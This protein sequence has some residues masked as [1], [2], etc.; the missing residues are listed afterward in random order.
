MTWLDILPRRHKNGEQV[1]EKMVNVINHQENANQNH[2]DIS[3]HIYKIALTKKKKKRQVLAMMWR[4]WNPCTLLLAGCKMMQLLWKTVWRFLK[5]LKIQLLYDP[6]AP[7]LCIYT[8]EL[9]S[10]PWR[11][12]STPVF[13]AA[14]I[15]IAK[16][17]KQP[18][19][20]ST[21]KW[22]KEMCCIHTMEYYSA[23]KKKE[24]LQYVTSY[25]NLEDIM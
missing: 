10:R 22:I 25:I 24:I 11:D 18:K 15:I 12:I 14:L 9:K 19:C 6:A 17:W 1:N 3:P 8:K 13:T 5:K 4:N 23:L 7:L 2:N 16:T 21:G 20:P